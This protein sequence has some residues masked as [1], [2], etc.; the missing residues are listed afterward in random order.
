MPQLCSFLTKNAKKEKNMKK[1]VD[2]TKKRWYNS[3][4]VR[5]GQMRHRKE[6]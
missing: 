3:Q 6:P 1:G 2:K 4:A 5:E